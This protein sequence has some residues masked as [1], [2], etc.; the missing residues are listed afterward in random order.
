[1]FEKGINFNDYPI[2]FKRG[3]YIRRQQL[4]KPTLVKGEM[5]DVIR[6]TVDVIDLPRLEQIDNRVDV[7][8]DGVNPVLRDSLIKED[9]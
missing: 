1:L 2:E 3:V 4:I 5:L 9:E 6:T 7:V 8:F